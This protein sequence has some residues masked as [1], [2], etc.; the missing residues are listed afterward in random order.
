MN[1]QKL[2]SHLEWL[3]EMEGPDRFLERLRPTGSGAMTCFADRE[4]VKEQGS[5]EDEER[6]DDSG[7]LARFAGEGEA[8]LQ[9]WSDSAAGYENLAAHKRRYGQGDQALGLQECAA[10]Y[11]QCSRHLRNL[12]EMSAP[13]PD[14]EAPKGAS[15]RR[16]ASAQTP[17]DSGTKNHE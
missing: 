10:I 9:T 7:G 14:S 8:L 3:I 1:K 17:P 5:V 12:I 6:S 16:N 13:K 11:R 15:G 4:A 2:L